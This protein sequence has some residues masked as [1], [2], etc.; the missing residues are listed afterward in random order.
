MVDLTIMQSGK[1]TTITLNPDGSGYFKQ[2]DSYD[3]ITWWPADNGG[4]ICISSGIGG[5]NEQARYYMNKKRTKMYWGLDDYMNDQ[6][7]YTIK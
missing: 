1:T 5:G 4:G 2:G 6:N 3:S 7:S